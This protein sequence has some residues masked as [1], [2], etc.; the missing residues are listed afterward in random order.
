M[1]LAHDESHQYRRLLHVVR[2]AAGIPDRPTTAGAA[3]G[4]VSRLARKRGS[5][6][7]PRGSAGNLSVLV[8]SVTPVGCSTGEGSAPLKD[9][10][11]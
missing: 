7:H 6:A 3:S 8:A 11:H 1:R 4:S 10:S 5:E 2:D 9:A